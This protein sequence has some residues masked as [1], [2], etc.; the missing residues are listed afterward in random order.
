MTTNDAVGSAGMIHA[1]RR[2]QATA[3]SALHH[4]DLVK[5]DRLPVAVDQEHD[6][7]TDS[8]LGG[9]HGDDEQGKDLT[10]HRVVEGPEGEEVDVDRV[11]DQLDGHENQNAIFSGQDSVD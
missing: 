7:Q 8:H 5:V 2:N 4:V 1:L 10:C 9:G 6:G 11:E 3:P